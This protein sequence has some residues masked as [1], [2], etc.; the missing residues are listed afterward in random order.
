MG[1]II[2]GLARWARPRHHAKVKVAAPEKVI[3]ANP[4]LTR[5]QG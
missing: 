5:S 2:M 3:V 1:A 4:W